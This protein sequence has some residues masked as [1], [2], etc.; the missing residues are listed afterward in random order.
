MGGSAPDIIYANPAKSDFD[1]KYARSRDIDLLTFDCKE[2]IWGIKRFHEKA[3]LIL[4]IKVDDSSSICRFNSKFGAKM[5]S[6]DEIFMT[7]KTAE[8][9]IVGVSFHVGSGCQRT[10]AYYDAI[11]R[12][13]EVFEMGKK[14]G[15]KLTILDIGG[16]FP[17]TDIVRVPKFEDIAIEINRAIDEFFNVADFDTDYGLRII[18]EPGRY[19]ACA[20]HTLV[21][22]IIKKKKEK[23]DVTNEAVF[24]YTLSD[25]VYG[26]FNC[27]IFDHATPVIMPFNERD[28]I[29]FKSVVFGPTCDSMDTISTDCQLPDLLPGEWV[30]IENFG[31]Y[32]SPRLQHSMDLRKYHVNTLCDSNTRTAVYR[33]RKISFYNNGSLA[34]QS[35]PLL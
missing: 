24:E 22:C 2:D 28:G 21:L 20:S 32:T 25:G 31:A 17:G 23:D 7:A 19:L 26:S 5:S 16:G 27:N 15:Y 35:D 4:R 29:T 18:A 30:Y 10:T 12:C 14:Y 1:L 6:L 8:L 11:K 33:G 9:K 13:R 3:D 34:P